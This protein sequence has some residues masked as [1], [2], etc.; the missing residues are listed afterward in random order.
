MTKRLCWLWKDGVKPTAA[1]VCLVQALQ[2]MDAVQ[3]C[4]AGNKPFYVSTLLSSPLQEGET[5]ALP[6]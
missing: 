2:D 5:S 3:L 1:T 4:R 6:G